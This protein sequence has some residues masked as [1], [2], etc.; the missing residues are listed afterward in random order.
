MSKI[1]EKV[2]SRC[3]R[4]HFII[5][6][7]NIERMKNNSH[8][9]VSILRWGIIRENKLA[10]TRHIFFFSYTS[11][12]TTRAVKQKKKKHKSAHTP[13][14]WIYTKMN[15]F[16]FHLLLSV[17]VYQSAK[18]RRFGVSCLLLFLF[19]ICFRWSVSKG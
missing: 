12:V 16:F 7:G 1:N 8:F 19:F 18:R 15:S 14:T 17:K 9:S 11:F 10:C 13:K 2:Y 5:S 6:Y 3:V 4:W